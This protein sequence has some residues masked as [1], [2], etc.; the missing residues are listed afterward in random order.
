M[1]RAPRELN[2]LAG[3]RFVGTTMRSLRFEL[4]PSVQAVEG[5]G[6]AFGHISFQPQGETGFDAL[7]LFMKSLQRTGRIDVRAGMRV[8]RDFPYLASAGYWRYAHH[9]LKWPQPARYELHIVVE[10][11]PRFANRI[12][13]SGE[14]DSH[15]VPRAAI[16]W[17]VQEPEFTTLRAFARHFEHYWTRRGLERI[18]RLEW[19]QGVRR[20]DISSLVRIGD[21][22][23]PGGTTR[24]G[25]NRNEGVVDRDLKTFA[26]SNLW[27]ASTSAFPSGASANPTMMLMLFTLRLADKLGSLLRRHRDI[28]MRSASSLTPLARQGTRT[29]VPTSI[30]RLTG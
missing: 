18:G 8:V 1:S 11:T 21:V 22:F 20:G 14:L 16:D 10:Q 29:N 30:G 23:H 24:I 27:V 17:C 4:A 25:M 9:Q 15:Q 2:Q 7:R 26:I 13:L 28:E 12:F 6:S 19:L 3:F 5:V